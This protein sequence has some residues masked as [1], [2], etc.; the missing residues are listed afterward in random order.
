MQLKPAIS[1]PGDVTIDIKFP[2]ANRYLRCAW[3]PLVISHGK[4]GLVL[5]HGAITSY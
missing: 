4:V 2:V 3:S 1:E 5:Y